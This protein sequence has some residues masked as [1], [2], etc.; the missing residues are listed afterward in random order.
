MAESEPDD[1]A[2][3]PTRDTPQDKRTVV[4]KVGCNEA[5]MLKPHGAGRNP[6]RQGGGPEGMGI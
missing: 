4:R 2:T 3:S 5:I 6:D 1:G